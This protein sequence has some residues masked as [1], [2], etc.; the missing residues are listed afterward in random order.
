[1]MTRHFVDVPNIHVD[2]QNL[3]KGG[4]KVLIGVEAVENLYFRCLEV[5]KRVR[6]R[7]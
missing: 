6:I 3:R 2:V 4:W 1:M 5:L 7:V